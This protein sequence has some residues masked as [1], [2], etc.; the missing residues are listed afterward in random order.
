V[1]IA[2][3]HAWLQKHPSPSAHGGEF[4]WHPADCDRDLRTGCVERMRGIE[5]PAVLWE[6]APG[7]VAWAQLF[8]AT[9]PTDHRHYVGVVLTIAEDNGATI[10]ELLDALTLPAAQP[11]TPATHSHPGSPRAAPSVRRPDTRRP[12]TSGHEARGTKRGAVVGAGGA[13]ALSSG[14]Q[15]GVN[16]ASRP[17]LPAKRGTVVGAAARTLPSGGH[18]AIEDPARFELSAKGGTIDAG[19]ARALL[20]GGQAAVDD[21]ARPELPAQIAVLERWM[22]KVVVGNVRRGVWRTRRSGLAPD[23]VAELVVAACREPG[24][25]AETGWRLLG[26]LA[27]AKGAAIDDVAASAARTDDA[28][29]AVLTEAER[30][31]LG[32]ARTFVETLHA[33]GRGRLER[34]ASAATA[35]ARF[36]D[37]LALRM[38]GRLVAGRDAREAIAEARWH[39]LLPSARRT[40]LLAEVAGRTATLRSL[41]EQHHA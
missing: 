12:D 33:W 11:W 39:A 41:V 32:G 3:R 19:V 20:S 4:H 30:A 13:R 31:A 36:A 14:A 29:Q 9:A 34:C 25:R 15:A 2:I 24:S 18:A 22:P 21:P 38:L 1:T 17:D 6:L 23:P 16:D 37:V 35:T 28:L 27:D 10:A 8:A 5:P 7:R 40:A 26:E